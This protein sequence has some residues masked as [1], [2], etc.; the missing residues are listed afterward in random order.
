MHAGFPEPVV[1]LRSQATVYQNE[2]VLELSWDAAKTLEADIMHYTI[3]VNPVPGDGTCATGVCNTTDNKFTITKLNDCV[4][5]D[6]K[7]Q[8]VNCAGV[9]N[10][11]HLFI[12]Y[13][14][15]CIYVLFLAVNFL[16]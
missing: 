7:V 15:S 2:D 14:E 16:L 5:Y 10:A 8:A 4:N 9:G 1:N 6:I 13:G 12:Q 11:T 3:Q